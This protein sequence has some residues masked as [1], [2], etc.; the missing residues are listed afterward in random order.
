MKHVKQL[1]L[2]LLFFPLITF[3]A[4]AQNAGGNADLQAK[5]MRLITP[6]PPGGSTD[7]LARAIAPELAK[8]LGT[9]VIVDNKPGASGVIGLGMVA[10]SAPDGYTIGLVSAG[11]MVINVM[12]MSQP[13]YD[14][15]TDL[16][17]IA[18]LADSPVVLVST[19][20]LPAK[21][22]R[23]LIALERSSPGKLSFASA[24]I[25]TTQHLAGELFNVKAGTSLVHVPYKGTAPAMTDIL[26]GQIQL[27]FMDIPSVAPHAK[28]GRVQ[29]L[30]VAGSRRAESLPDTPTL[31]ESGLPG[32]DAGAWFGM[33]APARTPPAII[34]RIS[35][36][37]ISIMSMPSI[38]GQL[39]QVGLEARPLGSQEF[40]AYLQSERSKWGELVRVL[41]PKLK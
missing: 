5:P 41:G 12:L 28:S 14:P 32:Y 34:Q 10:K 30:G 24:G 16:A 6:F 31:A 13:P 19:A 36:E 37:L 2:L 9:Q 20:S 4:S 21:D 33:V 11:N 17:P 29:L 35:G 25:G 27:G 8:R 38:R 26:G 18:F 3:T 22:V 40:A 39:V 23:A 7:V 1:V 15:V